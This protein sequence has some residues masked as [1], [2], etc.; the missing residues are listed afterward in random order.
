MLEAKKKFSQARNL[1]L[2]HT[3][4]AFCQEDRQ[5]FQL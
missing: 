2:F 3:D 5:F 4:Q 1:S